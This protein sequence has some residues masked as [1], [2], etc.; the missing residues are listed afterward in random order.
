MTRYPLALALLVLLPAAA[1]A[2]SV[3]F[4]NFDGGAFSKG[5]C[6]DAR[7]N[8][9]SLVAFDGIVVPAFDAAA[10]GPRVRV[11]NRITAAVAAAF[12]GTGVRVV[13]TRPRAGEYHM[14]VVGGKALDVLGLWVL[15]RSGVGCG[16][17]NKNATG[18][19]TPFFD[20]RSDSPL[21]FDWRRPTEPF[22]SLVPHQP[23]EWHE[24]EAGI[25]RAIA[26]E[27]GHT[28]GLVHTMGFSASNPTPADIMCEEGP[29]RTGG[30]TTFKRVLMTTDRSQGSC[31]G[32]TQDSFHTLQQ[33]VNN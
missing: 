28:Y 32:E 23:N 12:A 11:V 5:N 21:A 25:V 9:S 18:F 33:N 10:Y 2:E 26:H 4:L 31:G 1:S 7:S 22:L 19:V 8:C 17:A 13:S 20:G 29:C 30:P 27:A 15:G 3:L 14:I 16:N 24:S 6:D